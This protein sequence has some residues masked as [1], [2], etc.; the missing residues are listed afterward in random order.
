MNTNGIDLQTVAFQRHFAIQ[1]KHKKFQNET[2]WIPIRKYGFME[3]LNK[4]KKKK[5]IN[6]WIQPCKHSSFIVDVSANTGIYSLL[7]KTVNSNSKAY[8]FERV[9]RVYQKLRENIELHKFDIHT[10]E[11]ASSNS[12]DE[13]PIYDTDSEHTYSVTVNQNMY[14]ADT[15]VI[16][17]TIQT[18]KLDTFIKQHNISNID[19]IKID[20][21]TYEDEFLEGFLEYIHQFKPSMLVEI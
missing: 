2:F 16:A 20:V 3:W 14:S 1:V 19:L 15:K 21:E 5:S 10:Y 17:T 11:V 6:L 13:A 12:D 9:N 8:A 4:K 7:A 18:I